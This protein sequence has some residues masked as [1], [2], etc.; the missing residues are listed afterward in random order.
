MNNRP[1]M[2]FL[3]R[4]GREAFAQIETHLMTEDAERSGSRPVFF[5]DPVVP[6]RSH[7]IEILPHSLSSASFIIMSVKTSIAMR[8]PYVSARAEIFS[9]SPIS[10]FCRLLNR[11]NSFIA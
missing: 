7:Q 10:A 1:E 6:D 2:Q 3:C 5:P 11:T 9:P 4:H 8:W